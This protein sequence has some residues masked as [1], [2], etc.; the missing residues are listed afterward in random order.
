[1]LVDFEFKNVFSETFIRVVDEQHKMMLVLLVMR[2]SL[3]SSGSAFDEL[4]LLK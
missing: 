1:K 4:G 3:L 2:S